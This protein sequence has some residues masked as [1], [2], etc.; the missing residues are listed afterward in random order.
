MASV[1]H[2]LDKRSPYRTVWNKLGFS[3]L[4]IKHE[5]QA[6]E[7]AMLQSVVALHLNMSRKTSTKIHWFAVHA[8]L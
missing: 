4:Q 7:L 1:I 5:V 3:G 8:S 6:L 2:G